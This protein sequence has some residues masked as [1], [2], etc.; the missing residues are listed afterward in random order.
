MYDQLSNIDGV[1]ITNLQFDIKNKTTLRSR[2]RSIA[3]QQAQSNAEQFAQFAGFRLGLP[4]LINEQTSYSPIIPVFRQQ[5]YAL[6][7]SMD[8]VPQVSTSVTT[9]S[10]QVSIN[11]EYTF[12]LI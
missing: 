3:Y 7:A 11:T 6:A 9:G 8:A 1:S 10:F 5:N 12:Y 4:Q 2:A